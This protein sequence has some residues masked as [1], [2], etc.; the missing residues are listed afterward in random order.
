MM[1]GP[2]MFEQGHAELQEYAS[3]DRANS[4]DITAQG[5]QGPRV[6]PSPSSIHHP[7]RDTLND[8]VPDSSVDR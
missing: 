1:A 3:G 6:V 5:L 8:M 2:H 7:T 4:T